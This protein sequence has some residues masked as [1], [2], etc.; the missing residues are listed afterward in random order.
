MINI[1][2]TFEEIR[3]LKD[4]TRILINEV[5]YELDE[6]DSDSEINIIKLGILKNIMKKLKTR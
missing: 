4:M 1:E 5:Q 6:I 3:E 2:F